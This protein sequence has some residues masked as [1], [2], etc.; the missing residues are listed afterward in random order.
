[1]L[2]KNNPKIALLAILHQKSN[3][4]MV[5]EIHDVLI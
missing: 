2:K 1:M 3:I 5:I 4:V